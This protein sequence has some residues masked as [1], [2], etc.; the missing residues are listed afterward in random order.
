MGRAHK[1]VQPTGAAPRLVH[2]VVLL[3]NLKMD[4]DLTGNYISPYST[5]ELVDYLVVYG[6]AVLWSVTHISIFY[7][8]H[9]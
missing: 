8:R 1:R 7:L 9:C 5:V 6:I 3:K 4:E 2:N